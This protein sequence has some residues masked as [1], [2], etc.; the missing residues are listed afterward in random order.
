[1]SGPVRILVRRFDREG[2]VVLAVADPS[3]EGRSLGGQIGGQAQKGGRPAGPSGALRPTGIVLRLLPVGLGQAM[4]GR[5]QRLAVR[6][7]VGATRRDGRE[8]MCLP[9][10]PPG[11]PNGAT[12]TM[13]RSQAAGLGCVVG[14]DAEVLAAAAWLHDIGYAPELILTGFHPLDG[15]RHLRALGSPDRLANLVARH[16]CAMVEAKLRGLDTELQSFPDERGA[17]RDA[18]WY[19]DMTTAPDGTSVTLDERLD[20]IR[21]RYG[22]GV[23]AAFTEEA[24]PYLRGAV[25][26]TMHRL[27]EVAHERQL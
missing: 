23:V 12:P 14:S 4:A 24:R 26:R 1:M 9:A 19:C 2:R 6:Q 21:R 11:E 5:A 18:L 7:G 17:V 22:D 15:A 3:G 16:S 8:V 10:A 27:R 20:E 25:D 13:V